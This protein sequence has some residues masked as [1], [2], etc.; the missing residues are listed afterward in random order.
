MTGLA[1]A[2]LTVSDTRTK[3]NDRSGDYLAEAL[4]ANGHRLARRELV[5]DDRYEIRAIVSRWIAESEV[6]VILITGGTGFRPRDVTPEAVTPLFDQAIP[7][8]GELFRQL[9]YAE[10]G[11]ATIQSRACAGIANRTL[12]FCLPGSPNACR[13]AWQGILMEQLNRAHRPCNFAELLEPD[14]A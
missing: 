1:I 5:E 3:A 14:N 13:T 6:Q 8:Y 9:S 2:L 12:I 11:T 7:G 10:I 4:T